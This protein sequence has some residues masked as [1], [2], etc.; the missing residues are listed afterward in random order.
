[1]SIFALPLVATSELPITNCASALLELRAALSP[2][3]TLLNNPAVIA[4]PGIA[5][6]WIIPHNLAPRQWKQDP[7]NPDISII[8][9]NPYSRL[10]GYNALIAIGASRLYAENHDAAKLIETVSDFKKIDTWTEIIAGELG[11]SSRNPLN[12]N[13]ERVALALDGIPFNA[14]WIS[15]L[16]DEPSPEQTVFLIT[17]QIDWTAEET[18][19]AVVARIAGDCSIILHSEKTTEA[20]AALIPHIQKVL[21]R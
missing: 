3:S 7:S 5:N 17:K 12:L 10:W 4:H 14:Q 13:E 20:P 21:A 6:L 9:P 2:C 11:L 16:S 15:D 8:H 18:D 1:M 19:W